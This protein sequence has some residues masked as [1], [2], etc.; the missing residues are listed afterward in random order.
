MSEMLSMRRTIGVA[1]SSGRRFVG[2]VSAVVRSPKSSSSFVASWSTRRW[3]IL[4]GVVEYAFPADGEPG[5]VSLRIGTAH[6]GIGR[7]P[8]LAVDEAGQRFALWV[9]A[10]SCDDAVERLRG[11]GAPVTQEPEDQPWGERIA[12]VRDPDGNEVIVGQRAAA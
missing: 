7:V 2:A 4:G 5:Y 6:V 11:G 12:R 8:D 9:Y 10:E 1:T 3:Y